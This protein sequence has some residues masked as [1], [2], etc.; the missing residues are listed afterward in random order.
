MIRAFNA[1]AVRRNE[2]AGINGTP[3]EPAETSVPKEQGREPSGAGGRGMCAGGR[4]VAGLPIRSEQVDLR[5]LVLNT[6]SF[7]TAAT[8]YSLAIFPLDLHTMR[9]L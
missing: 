8:P 7:N 1:R 4:N 5:A 3:D 6:P 9:L 2:F